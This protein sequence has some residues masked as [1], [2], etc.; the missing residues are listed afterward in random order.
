MEDLQANSQALM[1]LT[2]LISTE[3]FCEVTVVLTY[4][5]EVFPQ[6]NSRETLLEADQMALILYCFLL[7]A[8]YL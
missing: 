3:A 7:S 2:N 4:P 6:Q 5:L 1:N 8:I